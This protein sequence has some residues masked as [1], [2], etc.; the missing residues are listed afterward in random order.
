[1]LDPSWAEILK[2]IQRIMP[3]LW[4]SKNRYLQLLAVGFFL[5]FLPGPFTHISQSLCIIILLLGR[6]VNLAIPLALGELIRVFDGHSQRSP[7]PLL[8]GYVAFRCLQ[9][10]GGLAALRD[11]SFCFAYVL[12]LIDISLSHFGLL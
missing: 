6:V 7:W 12:Q 4:P 1:M 9:G 3:Y 2:R 10:S 8:F 5:V 11:V